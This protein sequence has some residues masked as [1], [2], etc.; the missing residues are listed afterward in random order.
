M[1]L[2]AQAKHDTENG[3]WCRV[4]RSCFEAREGYRQE[5]GTGG[6]LRC[7]AKRRTCLVEVG[8]RTGARAAGATRDLSRAFRRL[9]KPVQERG[10]LELNRLIVRL[11]KLRPIYEQARAGHITAAT[12]RGTSKRRASVRRSLS[13]I[14]IRMLDAD[15]RRRRRARAGGGP[16][17]RRR[18]HHHMQDLQAQGAPQL[19]ASLTLA[20]SSDCAEHT[21]AHKRT[22]RHTDTHTYMR[23]YMHIHIHI[24][25]LTLSLFLC[26]CA[27]N[28]LD[29]FRTVA[30]IVVCVGA[31][32]V[33]PRRAAPAPCR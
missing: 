14:S 20:P 21:Q 3:V 13:L 23:T 32:C 29:C 15:G 16:V 24:H 19:P 17:G 30:A 27:A 6:C 10:D 2:N 9:R 18:G 1:K 31:L 4:C 5:L 25:T 8:T 22:Q 12:A 28:R 26:G 11:D 7:T 33:P